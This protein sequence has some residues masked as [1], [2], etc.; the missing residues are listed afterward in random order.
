MT[1]LRKKTLAS[2]FSLQVELSEGTLRGTQLWLW[3][4][5]T[6]ARSVWKKLSPSSLILMVTIL[7]SFDGGRFSAGLYWNYLS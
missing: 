1:L 5:K 3:V 6:P 4:G 2:L 7:L